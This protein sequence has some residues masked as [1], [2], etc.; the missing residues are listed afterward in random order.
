ML[1]HDALHPGEKL[2]LR[3]ALAA[4]G[5]EIDHVRIWQAVSKLKR[6][7][8]LIVE[9]EPREPGYR[10]VDWLWTARRTRSSVAAAVALPADS[11][12]EMGN[13]SAGETAEPTLFQAQSCTE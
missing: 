11:E 12:R 3:E 9:G 5:V 2:Y 10:V 8:R 13:R 4:Y 1:T 7:H 6:R